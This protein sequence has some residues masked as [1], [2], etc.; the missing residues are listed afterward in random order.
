M[1][2]MNGVGVT[3]NPGES[4]SP[5]ASKR[6]QVKLVFEEIDRYLASRRVDIRF[7]RE[8]VA[9]FSKRVSWQSLL[10]VGCGD[11]SISLPLVTAIAQATLLDMSSAMVA[12]ATSNV[13]AD[14]ADNVTVRCGD[15]LSTTFPT[16]PFDLIITVGVLAHVDSPH[17]FLAKI[18]S[19]LRPGGSLIIEFTDAH[20]PVGRLGRFWGALKEAVAPASYKTNKL[21]ASL[22]APLFTEQGFRSAGVFR[23]ARIPLPLIDRFLSAEAHRLVCRWIFGAPEKNTR[24]ALG[25]E[26]ICLFTAE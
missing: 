14:I 20:H 21:S 13:P 11:G 5:S 16:A 1:T 8:V 25:N 4:A 23:Y 17:L 26:Y 6:G 9:A 22:L 15:F 3:R 18:R 10:D 24:A 12:R 2:G 19:L 7:R